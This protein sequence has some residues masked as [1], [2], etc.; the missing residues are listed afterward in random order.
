MLYGSTGSGKVFVATFPQGKY[1]GTLHVPGGKSVGLCSDKSGNVFVPAQSS[2]LA[3]IYEF[4][5]DGQ[6]IA[7]LSDPGPAMG[8]SVDPLTGNLAVAD[9]KSGVAVY[10]NAQGGA[11]M[12][13]SSPA[14]SCTY[15]ESGNLFVGESFNLVG[16]GEYPKKGKFKS[17]SLKT[18]GD[19]NDHGTNIQWDGK[20]VAVTYLPSKGNITVYRVKVSG[21]SGTIASTVTLDSKTKAESGYEPFS[22][23][24]G[25]DIVLP[26]SQ[27]GQHL[28]MWGYPKGGKIKENISAQGFTVLGETVSVA[29]Q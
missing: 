4:N 16:L 12:L 18:I 19:A 13:T 8:C 3:T 10:A 24:Q 23:I 9:G 21:S 26:I 17:I 22:W 14:Y 7:G 5:H 25:K 1:I 28:G 11:T 2:G 29:T 20:Y 27:N 15:D 6:L